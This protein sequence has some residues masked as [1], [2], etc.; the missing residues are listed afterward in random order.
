[1]L[2][3]RDGEGK[4]PTAGKEGYPGLALNKRII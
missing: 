1:M 2:I 3:M 4:V